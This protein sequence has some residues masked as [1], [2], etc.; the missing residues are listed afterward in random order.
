[1]TPEYLLSLH[2]KIAAYAAATEFDQNV[3]A[4]MVK[5]FARLYNRCDF[6]VQGEFHHLH[7]TSA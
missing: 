3:F 4:R 5:E 7:C 2:R 6:V 1:M